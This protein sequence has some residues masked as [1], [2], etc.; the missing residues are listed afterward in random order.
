MEKPELPFV[1]LML[2]VVIFANIS[3]GLRI[4]K[5]AEPNVVFSDDFDDGDISDW[6]IYAPGSGEV[7]ADDWFLD[8]NSPQSP[9]TRAMVISPIYTLDESANYNVTMKFG[10]EEPIHW[11]EVF[12]NQHINTVIDDSAGGGAWRFKCRYGG[13]N[14]LIMNLY[15]YALYNIEYKVCPDSN[16]YDIYVGGILKR[17]CD[18]DPGGPAFPQFRMGDF[19]IGSD[20]YGEAI[21][22]DIIITQPVDSDE[23]G[24]LNPNDN[25]PYDYNPGQEDRNSDGLGDAC[26]CDA[27]NLDGLEVINFLD[28]STVA[29]DWDESGTGLAGDINSD[30]IVDFNDLE[31][32]AYHWL[33][34]C[35]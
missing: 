13:D 3:G 6:T 7:D 8:I 2:G 27:A 1:F 26:E 5:S 16:N 23:D 17:T 33:S 22:D 15:Q 25:C 14:Y 19:E 24:I 34:D 30:E 20:N 9:G 32:L 29:S 28:F 31:I 21:Y 12:R 4:A 18:C 11:I 35:N 10:F